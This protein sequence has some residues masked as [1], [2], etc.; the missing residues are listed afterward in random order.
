MKYNPWLD[1]ECIEDFCDRNEKDFIEWSHS[2]NVGPTIETMQTVEKEYC[3]INTEQFLI[4]AANYE[5]DL[6]LCRG[7]ECY[8]NSQS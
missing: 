8:D 4:F 6:E 1:K 7:D 2:K 5:E 3:R